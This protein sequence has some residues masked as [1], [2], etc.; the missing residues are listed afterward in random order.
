MILL[1]GKSSSS[2]QKACVTAAARALN[3]RGIQPCLAAI[4]VGNNP[5]SESYV[6]GK[7]RAAEACGIVSE[8]FRLPASTA[9]ASLIRLIQKLNRRKN[10]HGILL[11]LPLPSGL[12]EQTAI[13]AISPDKDVD[14]LHPRNL[15]NL[16]ANR[17]VFVPCTPKGVLHLLD[18]H[19]ISVEGKHV[20]VVGRSRLVGRPLALLLLVRNATV[21]ICHSRT[22]DLKILTRQADILVAAAGKKHLIDASFVRRGAVVVDVGIHVETS[23]DGKKIF[24]GDVHPGVAKIAAALSPVP[25]GVGPET[26]AQLLANTILAAS[27]QLNPR[28]K[29]NFD[30]THLHR[31]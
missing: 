25:G 26:V 11:Q 24:A 15:G 29:R 2:A 18:H 20:V 1:D 27:R 23:V 30:R 21:T 5:A 17:P 3:R 8:L 13:E 10:V 19:K 4:L 16:A 28:A 22:S 7:R 31:L 12:P 6:G 9:I 14:G